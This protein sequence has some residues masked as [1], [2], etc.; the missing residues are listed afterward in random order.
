[1]EAHNNVLSFSLISMT[2]RSGWTGWLMSNFWQDFKENWGMSL[3]TL[4]L[5]ALMVVT[6][7][8]LVFFVDALYA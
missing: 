5:W 1:M 6:A 7:L 4:I 8:G 2:G 3:L